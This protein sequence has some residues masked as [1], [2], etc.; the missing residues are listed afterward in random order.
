M[1]LTKS[2]KKLKSVGRTLLRIVSWPARWIVSF[3]FNECEITI[4]YDPTKKTQYNF[5][6]VDK[7][8]SKHLKG[9]LASGEPFELKTQEAFNF[10]IKK[11]K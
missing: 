4:W 8:E 2:A 9:R 10:Q 3:L 5:K 6:W 7:C 1:L 11:V